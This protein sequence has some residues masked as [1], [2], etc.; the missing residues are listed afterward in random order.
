MA[1]KAVD[2]SSWQLTSSSLL[3]GHNLDALKDGNNIGTIPSLSSIFA[4]IPVSMGSG[5]TYPWVQIDMGVQKVVKSV[6]F[7]RFKITCCYSSRVYVTPCNTIHLAHSYND[8]QIGKHILYTEVRVGDVDISDI[9]PLGQRICA[10]AVCKNTGVGGAVAVQSEDCS[11][12]PL[13][14]RYITL[15]RYGL[16]PGGSYTSL[17]LAEVNLEFYVP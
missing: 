14:G 6:Q 2:K 13:K 15:Q 4:S 10:N 7:Y 1:D 11:G 16:E 8:A 3:N 12:G 5:D 9:T 17:R